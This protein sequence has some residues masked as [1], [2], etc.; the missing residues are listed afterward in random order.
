M[1]DLQSIKA[2]L[3]LSTSAVLI[4]ALGVTAWFTLASTRSFVNERIEQSELPAIVASI[5]NDVEKQV[6]GPLSGALGVANNAHLMEWAAAGESAAGL[7]SF[8]AYGEKVLKVNEADS[9]TFIPMATGHYFSKTGLLKTMKR[10]DPDAGWLFAF[11]DSKAPFTLNLDP[12]RIC[13]ASDQ[14]FLRQFNFRLLRISVLR[15]LDHGVSSVVGENRSRY[16]ILGIGTARREIWHVSFWHERLM[17]ASCQAK[18][19]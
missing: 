2:R 4:G 15:T 17:T 1:L 3:L 14:L 12:D 16:S 6:A 8:L 19:H 5:R 13:A 11:M 10:G 7:K 9:I 18:D